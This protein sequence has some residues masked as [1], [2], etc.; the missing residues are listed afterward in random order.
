MQSKKYICNT[1]VYTCNMNQVGIITMHSNGRTQK[2]TF[3]RYDLSASWSVYTDVCPTPA[4]SV[5]I[6][7][8]TVVFS[9][10]D[11]ISILTEY[12]DKRA[13]RRTVYT[14]FKNPLLRSL[15]VLPDASPP[16]MDIFK[17]YLRYTILFEACNS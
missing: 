15:R 10:V 14:L 11:I 17:V 2:S 16:F 3:F 9:S 4:S 1:S 12:L 7:S 5:G 6:L 13:F 8:V